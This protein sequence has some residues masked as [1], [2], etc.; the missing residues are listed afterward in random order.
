MSMPFP[1]P[2]SF[3]FSFPFSIPFFS[4]VF[5]LHLTFFLSPSFPSTVR[6]L[7]PFFF[8]NLSQSQ[9]PDPK[10][11]MSCRTQGVISVHPYSCPF[12]AL[13]Q[14][15]QGRPRRN[16]KKPCRAS[17]SKTNGLTCENHPLCPLGHP[18]LRVPCLA[19]IQV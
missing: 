15:L 13:P 10:G 11:A 6:S 9:A 7:C 19:L 17:Q 4:L 3:T 16:S 14:R 18:L 1:F 5:S 8:R 2:F 12:V